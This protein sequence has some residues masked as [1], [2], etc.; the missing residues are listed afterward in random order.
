[1]ENAIRDG[2]RIKRKERKKGLTG[3]FTRWQLSTH[4]RY[5]TANR[6]LKGGDVER[7]HVIFSATLVVVVDDILSYVVVGPRILD[8][9]FSSPVVHDEYQ[10]EHCRMKYE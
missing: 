10:D 2:S 6:N 5:R 1:M 8:V 9:R 4:F 7:G 3:Y